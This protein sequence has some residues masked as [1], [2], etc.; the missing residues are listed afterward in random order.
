MKTRAT[1]VLFG[2]T[3][4]WVL[5]LTIGTRAQQQSPSPFQRMAIVSVMD[6]IQNCQ[7]QAEN[8][9]QL[10][11]EHGQYQKE[12]QKEDTDLQ[13]EKQM[14]NQLLPGTD[15]Y[16]KQYK[17]VIDQQAKSQALEQYYNQ[18]MAAKEM[19]LRSQL[20][21]DILAAINQ[22]AEAKGFDMVFERTEP[23]FP[24]PAERF[25]V[26]VSTH[27]LIYCK[28]CIDITDDVIAVVDKATGSQ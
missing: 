15:D 12:L 13:T 22:V 3:M 5:C 4:V 8:I 24:I 27:K 10:T 16:M 19:K 20:Y 1:V 18:V 26:T 23:E 25:A 2:L 7:K 9:K 14:L 11:A 17:V 21:K 28:N 6:V